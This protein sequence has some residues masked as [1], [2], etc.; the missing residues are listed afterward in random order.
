MALLTELH[1]PCCSG[2]MIFMSAQSVNKIFQSQAE[3]EE[4]AL[5]WHISGLRNG[6]KSHQNLKSCGVTKEHVF[7][8]IFGEVRR[9]V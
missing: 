8:D 9:L 3:K 7:S 2:M 5:R 6:R 4:A 1:Q